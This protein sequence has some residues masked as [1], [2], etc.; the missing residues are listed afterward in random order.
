MILIMNANTI[1]IESLESVCADRVEPK[2]TTI[3]HG[4]KIKF[5]SLANVLK[6]DNGSNGSAAGYLAA[7]NPTAETQNTL[8]MAE[9]AVNMIGPI[10]D[11]IIHSISPQIAIEK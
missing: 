11:G 10:A 1:R 9:K 6:E 2:A 5:D 8:N 7:I 3:E 4:K